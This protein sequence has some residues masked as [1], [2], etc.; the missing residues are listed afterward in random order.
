MSNVHSSGRRAPT[1]VQE[2]RLLFFNTVE[3]RGHVAVGEEYLPPDQM[4]K[5]FVATRRLKAFD[6]VVRQL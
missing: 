5:R 2:E 1:S 6:E 4:V 3:Y